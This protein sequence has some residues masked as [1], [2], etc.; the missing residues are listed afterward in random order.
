[1]TIAAIKRGN[2]YLPVSE[3]SLLL[4][5]IL[6]LNKQSTMKKFLAIIAIAG[7]MTACDNAGAGEEKKDSIAPVNPAATADSIKASADTINKAADTIKAKIDTM[8]KAV[9][10]MESKMEEKKK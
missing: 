7:L 9:D 3:I 8:K 4:P 6:K 10:K 1:L 2:K 5:R